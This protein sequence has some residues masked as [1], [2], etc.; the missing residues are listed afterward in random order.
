MCFEV[1]MCHFYQFS[2]D[3]VFNVIAD[4]YSTIAVPVFMILAFVYGDIFFENYTKEKLTNRLK[5]IIVPHL[6]WA[7]VYFVAYS[8]R[9]LMRGD[10]HGIISD[11]KQLMALIVTGNSLNRAAWF[12]VDLIMVTVLF[13]LIRKGLNEKSFL[14]S[15]AGLAVIALVVQYT[16]IWFNLVDSTLHG[17]VFYWTVGRFVE[18]IPMAAL[19]VFACRFKVMDKIGGFGMRA[20]VLVAVASVAG[21]VLLS[22]TQL[23]AIQLNFMYGGIDRILKACF[24]IALFAVLGF[25]RAPEKVSGAVV[26]VSKRTM[27]VY[28]MHNLVGFILTLPVVL[29]HVHYSEGGIVVCILIFVSA[30]IVAF[31][32]GQIPNKVVK[33]AMS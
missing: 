30:M 22:Y 28:Y 11:V 20:R 1:V 5:R 25:E 26:A 2:R 18:M 16:G 32:A 3:G 17:N 6:F 10:L 7:V 12:I 29:Q 31:L 15:L 4:E 33:M 13:I 24:T 9:D 27:A 8:F 23:F 14:Y 19:G 21:F